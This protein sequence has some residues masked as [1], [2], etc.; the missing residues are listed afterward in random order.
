MYASASRDTYASATS[1]DIPVTT[2]GAQEFFG[3]G[4][5]IARYHARLKAKN[6]HEDWRSM[7]T[8][9][10]ITLRLPI[11]LHEALRTEAFNR[12]VSMSS[13]IMKAVADRTEKPGTLC[14]WANC[15]NTPA[16][17]DP[18]GFHFCEE[19]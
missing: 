7:K 1:E 11:A 2:Q 17:I 19:H 9:Q 15:W 6:P 13:I 16:R 12:R 5:Q 10:A 18:G 14:D 3:T 8:E 4:R